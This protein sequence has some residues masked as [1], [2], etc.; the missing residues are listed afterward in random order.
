MMTMIR[1]CPALAVLLSLAAPAAASVTCLPAALG[2]VQVTSTANAEQIEVPVTF[3]HPFA[4]GAVRSLV[5]RDANGAP[6]PL[7]VD[8]ISSHTDGSVRFAIFTTRLPRLA[9]GGRA[10]VNLLVGEAEPVAAT[11]F[12]GGQDVRVEADLYSAQVSQIVF[13]NRDGTTPGIPFEAGETVAMVLGDERFELVVTPQ[14]AGGAHPTLTKMA[15]AFVPLINKSARYRAYKL[16]EGGGYEKLWVTSR[17]APGQPFAIRFDYKGRALIEAN[18]LQ[19]HRP[20]SRHVASLQRGQNAGKWLAGP[21]ANEA[22]VVSPLVEESSGRPHP[23]LTARFHARQYP[24]G[25]LRTDVV[26]ENDWAYEPNPGNLSYDLVIRDGDKVLYARKGINHYH[27]AR[28]HQVVWSGAAPQIELRHSSRHLFASRAVWNYDSDIAEAALAD[29]KKQLDAS[30][31]GPMGPALLTQYM[32]MTGGRDDIGPVPRWT[33]MF[34]LTQDPRARAAMMAVADA[35]G[36]VPIHYRDRPTN[37]PVS[38]DAHPGMAM[39]RGKPSGRDAFPELTNSDTPWT[40]DPAHQPSLAYVPYLVTGDQFYLDEILFWANYDMA[41]LDPGYRGGAK[42]LVS[43]DQVRAQAWALRT[44]G[45]AARAAA[46]SHPMKRYFTTRLANN[47]T[48]YVERYPRNSNRQISPK[49][50]WVEKHDGPGTTAPWQNDFLALVM[51]QLAEAGDSMAAEFF[52]WHARFTV[53]RWTNQG[54]GYCRAMAPAYYIN[55]RTTGGAAIEDW[56]TLFRLNWPEV[57]DCPSSFGMGYPDSPSGYVA[58]SRAMLGMAA[59]L[60]AEGA[61]TAY[62]RLRADTPAMT[63]AFAKDPTWAVAPREA[64]P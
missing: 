10:T 7:Q 37:Q 20:I 59:G 62:G 4:P 27:H 30:D 16:G 64:K 50:A 33:A 2:C 21:L 46:D 53:G 47:L 18:L 14:L 57:K 1:L 13:G 42:G 41:S 19:P 36:S 31:T 23:Q 49:L 38:L 29:V 35:A 26:M 15:E 54:T 12:P 60:G 8:Q 51:G 52:H 17:E 34:L 24:D 44:L 43:Q 6:L 61:E 39:S 63:A 56:G 58:V 48:W 3:G 55:L 45:E 40:P 5:A 9:G 11:E 25:R 32:P 22:L 28:W